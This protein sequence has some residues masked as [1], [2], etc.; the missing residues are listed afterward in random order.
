VGADVILGIN[1]MIWSGTIFAWLSTFFGDELLKRL[2]QVIKEAVSEGKNEDDVVRLSYEKSRSFGPLDFSKDINP[3]FKEYYY[4]RA[5]GHY[6]GDIGFLL[7]AVR[8]DKFQDTLLL[9]GVLRKE[10]TKNTLVLSDAEDCDIYIVGTKNTVLYCHVGTDGR[11]KILLV[12]PSATADDLKKLVGH[13]R[14]T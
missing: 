7:D 6:W 1:T 11:K 5:D 3:R 2:K 14:K 8:E 9:N 12:G 4:I 10:R 13:I